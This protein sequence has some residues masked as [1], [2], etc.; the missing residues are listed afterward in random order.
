MSN[1]SI[2]GSINGFVRLNDLISLHRPA[3][4][5]THGPA[6]KTAPALIVLCTWMAAA[7]RHIAK[8]TEGYRR[9]FPAATILLIQSYYST[10]G[11]TDNSMV[12]RLQPAVDVIKSFTPATGPIGPLTLHCFS[13]G[14]GIIAT[15]LALHLKDHRGNRKLFDRII[16]ECLPSRANV[17]QGVS[18]ISYSLP[19]QFLIR[20]IGRLLFR[21]WFWA[22]LQWCWISGKEDILTKERRRLNAISSDDRDGKLWNPTTPRLYLYSRADALVDAKDV[23]DHAEDARR[24]G[25]TEVKEEVF[26]TAPHCNLPSEDH[27]R[28]WRI[29][30]EW[31]DSG[32]GVERDETVSPTG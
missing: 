27:A 16:F 17:S 2:D 6:Q 4:K 10:V 18:A 26:E 15:H 7:P 22:G 30:E 19:K 21:I 25:F 23:H 31:I 11:A 14:G 28:Y 1:T 32:K 13:N 5:S 20:F 29:V 3:S 12:N 9:M 8:Y 24:V